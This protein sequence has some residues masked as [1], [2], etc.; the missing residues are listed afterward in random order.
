LIQFIQFSDGILQL[1]YVS[2][3]QENGCKF[4]NTL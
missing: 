2:E 1:K 4:S 3:K